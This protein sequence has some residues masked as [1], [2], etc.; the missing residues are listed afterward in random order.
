MTVWIKSSSFSGLTMAVISF[1]R[2]ASRFRPA[3]GRPGYEPQHPAAGLRGSRGE[4]PEPP[5]PTSATLRRSSRPG[6][7]GW[8][9]GA[10]LGS[11][12]PRLC[13][14]ECCS[15]RG[16]V[17]QSVVPAAEIPARSDILEY[18]A[19]GAATGRAAHSWV[20]VP[21]AIATRPRRDYL[22]TAV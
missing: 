1:M 14:P 21:A 2:L 10:F 6:N 9:V 13:T 18:K 17:R 15:G 19:V 20:H 8:G 16:F 22:A 4:G 5:W 11:V 7:S 3:P 12:R